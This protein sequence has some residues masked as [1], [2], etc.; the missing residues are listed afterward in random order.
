MKGLSG[1]VS[2]LFE[3]TVGA[4]VAAGE[5][6]EGAEWEQTEYGRKRCSACKKVY[7]EDEWTGG[8]WKYCPVCGAAMIAKA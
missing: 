1:E 3:G 5:I 6:P 7:I 4:R 8:E 2:G